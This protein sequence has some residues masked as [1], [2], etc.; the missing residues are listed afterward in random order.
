MVWSKFTETSRLEAVLTSLVDGV[1]ALN[2]DGQIILVNRAAEMIFK[3]KQEAVLGK[4]FGEIADLPDI[5]ELIEN[6]LTSGHS[7]ALEAKLIPDCRYYFNVRVA[8]IKERLADD[9]VDI[10]GAVIIFHDITDSHMFDQIRTE[11]VANV[12]HELRTPLTSIKGF[13]ETLID[14]ALED[15]IL[16][17]KFLTII[18][19]ET[20]RLSRLIDDLLI[21]SSLEFKERILN[22]QPVNLVEVVKTTMNILVPQAAD[23]NLRLELISPA[24][25]PNVSA[26]EDLIGQVLINLLDNA[27]KYTP[28]D[29]IITIRIKVQDNMVVT[30][31]TD[32][33]VGIPEENQGRLFERFYRVDKARSRELGGTGLGL[34]IVKHI[35]DSHGGTVEV[36]SQ[37]GKGSTFIFSLRIA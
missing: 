36:Q 29:G 17:R 18:D 21:L 1:V 10:S 6:A 25:L 23:K 37:V 16:C 33:G 13:V 22:L 7:G 20:D 24:N 12:S 2:R 3:Q 9:T 5:K 11:F 34:S 35:V 14:G 4:N 27:I 28:R 30:R 15:E 26:D 31:V 19:N 32:S 8:P